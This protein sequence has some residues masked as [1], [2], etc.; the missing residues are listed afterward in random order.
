MKYSKKGRKGQAAMEFLTTYGWAFLVILLVIGGLAYFDVFN[1]SRVLPDGCSIDG[2][3][4][5][6]SDI[7]AVDDDTTAGDTG[8]QATL[9]VRNNLQRLVTIVQIDFIERSLNDGQFGA[10]C[11][12]AFS[13]TTI[14]PG[15][16]AELDIDLTQPVGGSCG[17]LENID[18][19]K[20]FD[21]RITYTQQGSSIQQIAK[22]SV[23]TT[24]I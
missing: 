20:T 13:P 2:A 11:T 24:V 7:F 1:V 10:T 9:Q 23:T 18:Q 5:D 17:V 8:G 22:G 16:Q 6:C 21:F 4:F 12:T 15:Q 19:K 14:N 3:A